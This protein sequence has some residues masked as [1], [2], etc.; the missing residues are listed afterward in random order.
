[1]LKTTSKP[2]TNWP[3][4]NSVFRYLSGDELLA[5]NQVVIEESGGSHGLR[6]PGLLDSISIKPQTRFSGADLY[7]DPFLKAAVL[8]ESLVNYH[9]FID[10]N[11]RTGFAA[12]VRFLYIN[13]YVL[14]MTE[15]EIV[16]YTVAVATHKP[17]LADIA[18]WIKSH[19]KKLGV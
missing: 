16:R 14:V 6:E 7:P 3:K 17:D 1:M 10:G 15:E 4:S 12:M 2:L 5:I 13:G 9:V 8:F 11:K 19:A 18:G